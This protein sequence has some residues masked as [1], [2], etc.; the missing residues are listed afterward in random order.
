MMRFDPDRS[1]QQNEVMKLYTGTSSWSS[2][3][4]IGPFYPPGTAPGDML[5]HYATQFSAVEADVTYYRIPSK[6][7]IEGW[8]EKTPES[9]KIAAKFPREIVHGGKDRLPDASRILDPEIIGDVVSLFLERM[10]GLGARCGPLVIQLPYYNRKV[11]AESEQFFQRLT[12]FLSWLPT[13][14]S[15]G[16]EVRNRQYLGA[17]LA[18]ILRESNISLVLADMPYMP[19]PGKWGVE[20]DIITGENLYLRLIGDR[21]A[22]EAATSSFDR[23]VVDNSERLK[24]W[25]RW[26]HQLRA[27]VKSDT[28]IFANNHFAGHGPATIREFARYL[29]QF[30]AQN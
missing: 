14:F 4:W 10:S 28:F 2:K 18:G 16:L 21:K 1:F 7:M 8:C 27:Q 23:I 15:Y 6:R 19:W 25:A 20:E 12:R 9:F 24:H 3:D 22:V 17:T 26:I 5:R 13:G 11:F 29:A 30:D